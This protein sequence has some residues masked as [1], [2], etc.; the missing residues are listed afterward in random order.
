MSI[1]S[2]GQNPEG[3]QKGNLF[4]LHDIW[5]PH[6]RDTQGWQARQLRDGMIWRPYKLHVWQLLLCPLD[7]TSMWPLSLWPCSFYISWW[8][9]DNWISY[10]NSTEIEF[11][12]DIQLKL[13]FFLIPSFM[14]AQCSKSQCSRKKMEVESP[15]MTWLW[16]RLYSFCF[17]LLVGYKQVTNPLVFRRQTQI[18]L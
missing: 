13:N 9:W 11:L 10:W 1:Y 3:S 8:P 5:D 7:N 16:S 18:P 2:G 17:T 4:L 15:F 6:P 14:E 12:S